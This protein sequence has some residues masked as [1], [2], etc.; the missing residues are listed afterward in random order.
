VPSNNIIVGRPGPEA[1]LPVIPLLGDAADPIPLPLWPKITQGDF[2]RLCDRA[3]K[4]IG[5]V[6][7]YLINSETSNVRFRLALKS[8]WRIFIRSRVTNFVHGAM[9]ADLVRRG[10]IEGW[11]IPPELA[12]LAEQH[13]G[14]GED[15]QA[16][17][18][19]LLHPSFD[20]RTPQSVA[21]A[22]HLLEPFVRNTLLA[23]TQSSMPERL[24]TWQDA[25]AF[26][27]FKDRPGFLARRRVVKWFNNWW[28]APNIS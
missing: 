11:D 3:D 15:V 24:R 1:T 8:G 26:T 6:V 21:K 4:R 5:A 16:I 10:Q 9:L 2:E 7:P 28:N 20:F 19:E 18:A 23:L 22:T 12:K 17:L 25:G 14:K 27:F 13:G